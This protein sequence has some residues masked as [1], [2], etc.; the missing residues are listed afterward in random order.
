MTTSDL[1]N[2]EKLEEIYHLTVENNTM[3]HSMHNRERL[4]MIIR[5]MY[6]LMIIGA[7]GGTYYLARPLIDSISK[8]T[9]KADDVLQKVEDLRSQLP[10]TKAL[11]QMLGQINGSTSSTNSTDTPR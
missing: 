5:T 10:E 2:Q 11:K 7:L 8:N 3:L 1:T 4:A 9:M 6:W